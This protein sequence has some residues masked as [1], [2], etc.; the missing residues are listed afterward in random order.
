MET[1]KEEK[2]EELKDPKADIK[3]IP[4]R[5][6]I[7]LTDGNNVKIDKAEVSGKLEL[8]AILQVVLNFI[9]QQK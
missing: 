9:N 5:Q 7:I 6:I 4:M 1:E 3:E 8:T 2:K